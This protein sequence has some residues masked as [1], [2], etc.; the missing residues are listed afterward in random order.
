[1]KLLTRLFGKNYLFEGNFG[2]GKDND[3]DDYYKVILKCN[4]CNTY[5]LIYIKK[6][7]YIKNIR[8]TII[9]NNCNCKL[10]KEI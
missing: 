8:E 9:C 5:F 3:I 7:I 2:S 4:N 10:E 1:M 6:R